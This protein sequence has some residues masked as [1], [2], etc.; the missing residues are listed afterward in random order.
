M[1]KLSFI[2]AIL[3]LSCGQ[4]TVNKQKS[5]SLQT[6]T[7]KQ[8]ADTTSQVKDAFHWNWSRPKGKILLPASITASIAKGQEP[9]DTLSGDLNED[10]I[11]DLVLVTGLPKEDSLQFSKHTLPRHLLVFSGRENGD[12]AFAF[13]NEKAIPC[14]G[15]CGMTD[16]YAGMSIRKG[17][18]IIN[19]YCASNWKSISEH[20]FRYAPKLH[21]WLLDTVVTETFAF[22]YEH[23]ELDTTT[24]KDFGNVSL[25]TF[26]MY[27]DE[28]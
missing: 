2:I 25:K 19:E 5:A 8:Y 4:E 27:K 9:I 12:Y 17:Q 28:D 14:I 26:V 6:D 24:K 23:Y 7:I 15:C 10:G 21:D 16:P 18:L 20:R 11:T 22:H 13:R 3:L 1:H